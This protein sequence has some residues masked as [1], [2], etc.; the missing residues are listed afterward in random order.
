MRH[1]RD[2]KGGRGW[3][4][5]GV[6]IPKSDTGPKSEFGPWPRIA[7]ADTPATATCRPCKQ[8]ARS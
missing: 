7:V 8:N 5:C 1:I 3:T 2:E 4:H 6:A